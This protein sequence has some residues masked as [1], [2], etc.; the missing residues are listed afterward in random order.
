[1]TITT[2]FWSTGVSSKS[3]SADTD[4]QVVSYAS[5]TCPA[6]VA[7]VHLTVVPYEHMRM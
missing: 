6:I 5:H 2:L 1:M 3:F 4:K 7:K